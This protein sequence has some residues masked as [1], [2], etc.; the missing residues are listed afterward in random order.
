MKLQ[1]AVC[2]VTGAGTG[3]GAACAVQLAAK[4]CRVVVNYSR[5][6]KEARETVKACE[7]AGGEVH[8]Q[9]RWPDVDAA[10]VGGRR[11]GGPPGLDRAHSP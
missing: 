2:I 6:E 9:R 10:V 8:G 5:S 11:A 3:S 4:G 7:A 1:G